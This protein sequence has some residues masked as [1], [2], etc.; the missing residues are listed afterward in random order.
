LTPAEGSEATYR[1]FTVADALSDAEC[2]RACQTDRTF[3]TSTVQHDGD[4]DDRVGG[5]TS[6]FVQ[7]PHGGAA[8]WVIPI[9]HHHVLRLNTYFDFEIS[10]Y[11]APLLLKYEHGQRYDWHVDLGRGAIST[12]KL[13]IIVMLSAPESYEGGKLEWMPDLGACPAARGTLV[14]FPSF[15]PH[16]VT[17]VTR[18]ERFALVTWAHGD[19][20]FR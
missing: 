20:A 6:S 1:R 5:L 8:D 16:R 9:I 7:L 11:S 14:V 10:G 13:S 17:P 12:R 2:R 4:G 15:M 18:G 3:R 19:R